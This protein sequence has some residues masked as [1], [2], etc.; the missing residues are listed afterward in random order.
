MEE[1]YP[2]TS[3]FHGTSRSR[4]QQPS[5][6]PGDVSTMEDMRVELL[7]LQAENIRQQRANQDLQA[8][9]RI[10]LQGIDSQYREDANESQNLEGSLERANRY[11]QDELAAQSC[12]IHSSYSVR[13]NE[14][15]ENFLGRMTHS[16]DEGSQQLRRFQHESAMETMIA[17]N[18]HELLLAESREL[19]QRACE[20][21]EHR[22]HR[23]FVRDELLAERAALEE[24]NQRSLTFVDV[25]VQTHH[26]PVIT[27]DESQDDA[28]HEEQ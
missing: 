6:H 20:I 9:H 17:G 24:A 19:E 15:G 12:R 21:R 13:V 7:R 26:A 27:V 4:S 16:Q 10:H 11:L 22:N 3:D 8:S 25:E 1:F 5:H 23:V 18:M 28:D 2:D 14:Y